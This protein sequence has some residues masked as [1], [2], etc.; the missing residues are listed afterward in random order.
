MKRYQLTPE[1]EADLQS[2]WTYSE[3]NWSANQADIYLDGLISQFEQLVTTPNIGRAYPLIDTELRI[4]TVQNHLI[5]YVHQRETILIVRILGGRQN[6]P[7][8]LA[9]LD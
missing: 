9:K 5:L 8:L 6:W 7:A 1:A 4:L 3:Q 2:I